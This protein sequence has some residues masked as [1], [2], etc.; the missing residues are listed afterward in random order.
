MEAE[1]I[2]MR[3]QQDDLLRT[4]GQHMAEI[5]HELRAPLAGMH[6]QLQVMERQLTKEGVVSQ[7]WR[8]ALL[9]DEMSRMSDMLEQCL[10]LTGRRPA[11]RRQLYLETVVRQ[12]AELLHSLIVSRNMTCELQLAP[13]LP[14][15]LADERLLKQVLINLVVNAVEAGRPGGH[16]C[17]RLDMYDHFQRIHVV[18]DGAGIATEVLERIWEPFFTTKQQGTGLGLAIARR[19]AEEHGGMLTVTSQPGAGSC[20]CFQ[21]PVSA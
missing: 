12:V 7:Q 10:Q 11:A 21:L 8:F 4:L 16:L 6:G 9:Y 15:V 18:D 2:G 20:F 1:I 17:L 14:P 3:A 19:I 13:S 5:V